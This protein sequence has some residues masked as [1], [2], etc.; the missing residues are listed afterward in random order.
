MFISGRSEPRHPKGS[1]SDVAA[2]SQP[3]TPIWLCRVPAFYPHNLIQPFPAR[4]HENKCHISF[5]DQWVA[6][7]VSRFSPVQIRTAQRSLQVLTGV[8]LSKAHA[9][10][11]H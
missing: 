3:Y 5:T 7:P 11:W 9:S 8:E 4:M 6:D 1:I 2:L 10:L